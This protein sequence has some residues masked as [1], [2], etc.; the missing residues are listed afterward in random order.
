MQFF[1]QARLGPRRSLTPEGFLLCEAVPIARAGAMTYAAGEVPVAAG[2]DGLV[3]I[4]RGADQVFRRET[5]ASFAGKPVTD[6]HPPED[7]GPA[8]WK[9]LAV[10]VVQNVRPGAGADADLLLADLLITDAAAIAAVEAGK[11][12]VSCGYEADYEALGPGRGRQLNILGNHVALVSEGRCG[13]RCA[14]GDKAMGKPRTVFDRIRTAFRA[15]DEAALDAALEEVSGETKEAAQGADPKAKAE[16]KVELPPAW[17]APFETRL[18]ALEKALKPAGVEDM[19]D[20]EAEPDE[21]EEAAP[22]RTQDAVALRALFQDTLARA[23]TLHPGVRL[24]TYDAAA[25]RQQVLDSLCALR[26]KTLKAALE[27]RDGRALVEPILG[28]R[29]E[30]SRLTC[31]AVAAAFAAASEV[32]RRAHNGRPGGFAPRAANANSIADINARNAAFWNGRR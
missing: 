7:V 29:P 13:P 27:T 9:S 22:A 31:D 23:E 6:D 25:P 4:E 1:T 8:N 21:E 17:F 12:E 11:R 24:P 32:A 15:R 5:I 20:P 18:A 30:V 28:A 10:G 19:A 14:I 3:V 16:P 26:R 2:P